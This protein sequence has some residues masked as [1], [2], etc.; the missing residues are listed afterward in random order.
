MATASK[1]FLQSEATRHELMDAARD[2]FTERGY[3]DTPL[4]EVVQRAGVTRGALYHHFKDKEDL[5]RAVHEQVAQGVNDRVTKA[6]GRAS[7]PWEALLFG[8]RAFLDSC[9]D[10]SVQRIMLVDTGAVL[11]HKHMHEEQEKY[12]LVLI[13]TGLE[14]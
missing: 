13:R 10:P 1:K 14:H 8:C 2:L 12:D 11:G 4:E 3:A 7:N 9:L 6:I 5:F